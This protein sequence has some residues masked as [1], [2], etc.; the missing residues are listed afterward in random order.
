MSLYGL[1]LLHCQLDFLL[2][3]RQNYK[4]SL[5]YRIIIPFFDKNFVLKFGGLIFV[6]YICK[7]I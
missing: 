3:K 5:I 6:A 1:F 4:I 2:I 7:T